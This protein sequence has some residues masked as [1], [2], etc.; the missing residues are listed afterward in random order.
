[1]LCRVTLT[2][3][4]KLTMHTFFLLKIR[5]ISLKKSSQWW[6]NFN[7]KKKKKKLPE[8]ERASERACVYV[9]MRE[10]V[11]VC[12]CVC[13]CLCVLHEHARAPPMWAIPEYLILQKFL[14]LI[15]LRILC[16][17]YYLSWLSPFPV[18]G[19]MKDSFCDS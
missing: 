19:A 17:R 13:V 18:K 6:E 8:S 12:V 11:R 3:T 16:G 1:M 2:H 9:C 7:F 14:D 4:N 10:C 15:A 5:K